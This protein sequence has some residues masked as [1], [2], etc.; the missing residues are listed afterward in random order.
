MCNIID[1]SKFFGKDSLFQ[2]HSIN[3]LIP[4]KETK[5]KNSSNSSLNTFQRPRKKRDKDLRRKLLERLKVK[6]KRK[7]KSQWLS[8]SV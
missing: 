6:K 7:L 8:N 5:L 1:K 2:D 4:L 3:F